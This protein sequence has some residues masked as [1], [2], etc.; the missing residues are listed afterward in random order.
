LLKRILS[1]LLSAFFVFCV[2]GGQT[3]GFANAQE[4]AAHTSQH[5]S[6]VG[7]SV[8]NSSGA[9]DLEDVEEQQ[10]P[11]TLLGQS[12]TVVLHYKCFP[13]KSGLD[14]RTLVS[15]DI[16]DSKGKVQH[17]E[18]F[19]YTIEEGAFSETCVASARLLPGSNGTGLLIESGYLP[20]APLTGGPWQ[21]FGVVGG[22]LVRFGKPL[23]MEGELGE[24][25]PGAISRTGNLKQVLPD[26][27]MVRIWTGYFF[28]SV[29]VRID[30]REGKLALG[31]HCMYQTGHGFAEEGCEMPA[32]EA[33][34]APREQEMTFVRM[35]YDSN[36]RNGP[37]AHVVVKMESKVEVVACKVLIIWEEGA[38][39]VYLSTGE[40]VW[41]KLRIDGQEGWIHTSEDLNA[42]GLFRSG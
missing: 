26:S 15:L 20:S 2:I 21:V 35:F 17:H 28:V 13:G 12:L 4:E 38:E 30:W 5:E 37:P 23:V 11:F 8:V 10:G 40:D 6:Q 14:S 18:S 42:I 25:V 39:I 1:R 24:F 29:P 27:L 22:N 33:R 3:L 34:I 32:E 36:D 16:R 7:Q 9:Q 19:P 31:Q 41:V